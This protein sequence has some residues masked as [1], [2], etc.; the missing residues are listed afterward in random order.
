MT[1]VRPTQAAAA[2]LWERD[3]EVAAVERALDTLCADKSS[4]GSLLVLRGEA[5]LGKTALLAETRRIAEARGCTVWSARGS[6]TLSSVP[7]NVVRQLLQ[8]ALLSLMPE[9]AR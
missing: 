4:S 5:G 8:P 1:E 2:S 6:E 3:E 9:E 7:F